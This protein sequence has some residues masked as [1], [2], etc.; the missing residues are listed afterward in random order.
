M[1]EYWEMDMKRQGHGMVLTSTQTDETAQHFSLKNSETFLNTSK[2]A[3]F[4]RKNRNFQRGK[5]E[6]VVKFFEN[7]RNVHFYLENY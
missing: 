6:K 7:L 1:M 4:N 2:C 5:V 3:L